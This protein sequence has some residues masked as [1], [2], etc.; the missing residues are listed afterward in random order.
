MQSAVKWPVPG[1][2]GKLFAI[3]QDLPFIEKDKTN[4]HFKYRFASEETIKRTI[5]PLLVKHRILFTPIG[6]EVL[7][8]EKPVTT[9][10]IRYRFIDIDDG[11]YVEGEGIGS[12]ADTQDKGTFKAL[13]GALKYIFTSQFVVPT[14]DD[15]ENEPK[16]KTSSGPKPQPSSGRKQ[17][18]ESA[19]TEPQ[20]NRIFA[21]MNKAGK[22]VDDVKS[23]MLP[24]G[25]HSRSQIKV[26]DYDAICKSVEG[27]A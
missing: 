23:I 24:Y 1:I 6:E 21:L 26:K 7:S 16:T 18:P 11:S 22:T 13:T 10:R 8:I 17:D 19:I 27:V 4:E 20:Q 14:G 9:I 12:G 15:P 5:Q 25:Y 2:Y 3:M